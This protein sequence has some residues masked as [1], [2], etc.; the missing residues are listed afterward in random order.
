MSGEERDLEEGLYSALQAAIGGA[1]LEV[2]S[3]GFVRA[4]LG[5]AWP[6]VELGRFVG[7]PLA[8]LFCAE[9][10]GCLAQLL[11][12]ARRERVEGSFDLV[13]AERE[14]RVPVRL[15]AAPITGGGQSLCVL[16]RE[17]EAPSRRSDDPQEAQLFLDAIIENLPDMIFVK[18][19]SELRFVRVNR[20][21]EELCGFSREDLLG[22]NDYDF[23]PLDQSDFFTSKDRAV[24][25]AGTPHD[26]PVE[27]IL[28]RH[29]GRRFLHTKK[30]P[31]FDEATGKPRY[32]LG[33]SEDI[34]E[35]REL[36]IA[37]SLLREI[38]HRVKNNLQVVESLLSLKSRHIDHKETRNLLR[39]VRTRVRS[40][41]LIHE[42]LHNSRDMGRIAFD[43][44]LRELTPILHRAYS[45]EPGLV[46]LELEAEAHSLSIDASVPCS[47]IV[48]E[49]VANALT[50]AFEPGQSG[51]IR[52]GFKSVGGARFELSVEDNGRGLPVDSQFGKKRS[53]I[54][55]ELVYGLAGQLEGQVSVDRSQGTRFVIGFSDESREE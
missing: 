41:A 24:F 4:K 38:H 40:M 8:E 17:C 35:R 9:Q 3:A 20:A 5:G 19:A 54:G 25:E 29:K 2:D 31:M 15:C 13:N 28:T 14:S 46:Q 47:L 36:E 53:S 43:E 23:F 39:D 10:A 51:L 22:K 6:G 55:L 34:T 27:P 45:A 16:L 49:L 12:R 21:F 18:E 1:S 50:H 48:N 30:V 44:H 37:R 52:V 7:R 26:I 42:R 32:L 33:I 11:E